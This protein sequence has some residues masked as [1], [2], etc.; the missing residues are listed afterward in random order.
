MVA[1]IFASQ[2]SWY[3]AFKTVHVI[4]AV[5]WIGGGALLTILGVLAERRNDPVELATIARQA[6]MVGEKLFSPAALVVLAMGISM[7]INTDWGWGSF[8]IDFGLAGFASTFAIGIGFLAPM[9]KKV[10][11]VI[12]ASGPQSPEAQAL[13]SRILLVARVDI[14]VLLLVIVDMVTKPFS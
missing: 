1:V 11:A 7:M 5:I 14:A 12:E 3:L 6:A 9:S 8:W 2:Q 10:T 13:I 4:F